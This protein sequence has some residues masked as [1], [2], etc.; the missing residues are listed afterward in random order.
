MTPEEVSALIG[1]PDFI[2][3][4]FTWEYDIDSLVP[5]TIQLAWG[6]EGVRKIEKVKPALW[7]QGNIR[8]KH[9]IR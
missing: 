2:T 4:R 8:D 5:M 6:P 3:D 1:Y 7:K 9:L